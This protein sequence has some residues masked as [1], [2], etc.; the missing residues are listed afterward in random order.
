RHHVLRRKTGAPRPPLPWREDT[1]ARPLAAD[2]EVGEGRVLSGKTLVFSSPARRWCFLRRRHAPDQL[3]LCPPSAR[4]AP[5][6]LLMV[7]GVP[8]HRPPRAA[9]ARRVARPRR[10]EL[11]RVTRAPRPPLPWG[12]DTEAR[13]LAAAAEVG[14]GR[15]LSGKTLVFSS[16]ARRWC[17]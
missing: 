14:E 4:M 6:P 7:E 1:E 9:P 5:Y 13:P 16:P 12:E 11:G 3:R 15:V 8:Q 17:F 2:A 10:H